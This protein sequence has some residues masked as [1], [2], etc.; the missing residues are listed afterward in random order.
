MG[1]TSSLSRSFIIQYKAPL[2]KD[3]VASH[4]SA[5]KKSQEIA[6]TYIVY[7]VFCT[8]FY[9]DSIAAG[10]LDIFVM[11]MTLGIWIVVLMALAWGMF[12]VLYPDEPEL[13]V[14]AIFGSTHKTLSMGIPLL[15]AMFENDSRL[16]L[17]TLPILIYHPAQL[18]LGSLLVPRLRAWA[19]SERRRLGGAA[20]EVL[21]IE[22]KL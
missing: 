4:K 21:L 10:G 15:N 7:C 11:G 12:A 14:F 5:F 20:V 2:I 16:G 1:D 8:T 6:L 3:F 17:Y 22:D 18:V 13:R 9:E 19:E